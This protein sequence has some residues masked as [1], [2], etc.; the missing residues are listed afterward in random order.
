MLV[1][2]QGSGKTTACGKLAKHL[3]EPGPPAAA[4]R[5]RPPAAGRRR[6]APGA[7]RA[8]RRPGVLA[9][10]TDPVKVAGNASAEA[11][12]LGRNIIVLDT[13]GRL[14]VDE[15]LMDEL[16]RIREA[17]QPDNM[18]LVVDAMTGQEAVNVARRST[19]PSAST[20]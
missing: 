3:Q 8:G 13:A 19:R 11:A 2:L 4:G 5:R 12:R 18:L 9:K 7:R 17:V 15:P 16:R 14:Q 6:A 20:A 1:G 10:P